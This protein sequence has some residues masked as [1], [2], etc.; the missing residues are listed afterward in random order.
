MIMLY[1]IALV[2]LFICIVMVLDAIRLEL[3]LNDLLRVVWFILIELV[4][5]WSLYRLVLEFPHVSD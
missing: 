1:P 3:V 5:V 4:L 2:L